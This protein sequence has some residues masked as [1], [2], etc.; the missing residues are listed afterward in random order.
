MGRAKKIAT[1]ATADPPALRGGPTPQS[2]LLQNISNAAVIADILYKTQTLTD[3]AFN[4]LVDDIG[5][6]AAKLVLRDKALAGD[7]RALELYHR[8]VKEQRL[9]REQ[10]A[11]PAPR[12]I[13]N[14]GFGQQQPRSANENAIPSPARDRTRSTND[15][16]SANASGREPAADGEPGDRGGPLAAG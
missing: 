2:F 9:E 8:I 10:R 12:A 3:D 13:A 1:K 14:A 15:E 5:Y 6:R 11:R 4:D 7:V 16:A